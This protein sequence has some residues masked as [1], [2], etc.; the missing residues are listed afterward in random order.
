MIARRACSWG[1]ALLAWSVCAQPENLSARQRLAAQVIFNTALMSESAGAVPDEKLRLYLEASEDESGKTLLYDAAVEGDVDAVPWDCGIR[2][3]SAAQQQTIRKS[4]V[5]E[6]SRPAFAGDEPDSDAVISY[7][8]L[9]QARNPLAR[10]QFRVLRNDVL[11]TMRVSQPLAYGRQGT[12]DAAKRR[13]RFFY[14]QAVKLRLFGPPEELPATLHDANPMYAGDG[15]LAPGKV[16]ELLPRRRGT[17]ADGA[18]KVIVRVAV[19][20]KGKARFRMLPHAAGMPDGKIEALFDGVTQDLSGEGG[21]H[22]FA[23]YTPPEEFGASAE[24]A[25]RLLEN[26]V[27]AREA[28]ME[29]RFEPAG[30]A[31]PSGQKRRYFEAKILLARP[32]VML[33]HGTYDTPENCW[34]TPHPQGVPLL[35]RLQRRGFAVYAVDYSA[36]NGL[37]KNAP[38]RFE[39]NA[40]VVWSARHNGIEKA[41]L[42]FRSEP[43]NLAATQADVVGHSLGGVLPRVYASDG[44]AKEVNGKPHAYLRAANFHEGD[45]N[46]LITIGSTH[47]GSDLPAV[48]HR[49]GNQR[50]GETSVMSYL[51]AKGLYHFANYQSGLETGAATD[52]IPGSDALRRIGPTA[53]PSHAIACI[54]TAADMKEHEG[55]YERKCLGIAEVLWRR[56]DLIPVAFP[57]APGQEISADAARLRD[58]LA[59]VHWRLGASGWLDC[60]GENDRR[61]LMLLI[62]AAVFGNTQ[63]DCTVRL[64]SQ[65]GGLGPKY[66]S[67]VCHVLHGYAPRYPAVQNRVM[68]LLLDGMTFFDPDG[69]GDAGVIPT[70]MAPGLIA[71]FERMVWRRVDRAEAA[72]L[73]NLVEAH[74]GAFELVARARQTLIMTRP[75]NP[76]AR[77]LIRQNRATKGMHIKGKSANWGPQRGYIPVQQRFSKLAREPFASDEARSNAIKSFDKKVK[78]SIA[79]GRAIAVPLVA[80]GRTLVAYESHSPYRV[81]MVFRDEAGKLYDGESGAALQTAEGMPTVVEVLANPQGIPMTADYDLMALGPLREHNEARSYDEERGF[82][83]PWQA[84][85]IDELNAAVRA[86]GYTGG[87]VVHHG[88]ETNF[89]ISPGPDYPITAFEPPTAQSPQG[90]IISVPRG[91]ENDPDRFLKQYVKDA[92]ARGFHLGPNAVWG[93]DHH[94]RCN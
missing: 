62:R 94:D 7:Q 9:P 10:A 37:R 39:D 21:R 17:T 52:Q 92:T 38:S 8:E 28:R 42:D 76:D 47:Y 6:R 4:I 31:D 33:V 64:A 67:S 74:V 91:P 45:I 60:D 58:H 75:V 69:F 93:W 36:S 83:A 23:L 26:R 54:A 81:R 53:I 79:E 55:E 40:L 56:A 63:N 71:Q 61:V 3:L 84:R 72:R 18:C 41:L 59:A 32:P 82:V 24:R 27:E 20:E 5:E 34:N 50:L 46:R 19:T 90:A 89:P 15:Q 12:T 88:P 30:A 14:D 44:F 86:T 57:P 66:N 73:S 65:W 77:D 29:I 13:W 11:L 68:E 78:S 49:L 51:A 87:D 70:D 25:P 22:L 16:L 85:I 35:V 1:L 43:L 48:L 80:A 2:F